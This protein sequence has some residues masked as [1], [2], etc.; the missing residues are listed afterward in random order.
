ML[1]LGTELFFAFWTASKSVGL[2]ERSPPPVRAATSMFLISLA[3]SLPRLAS[4]PAFLCLVVAHLEWPLIGISSLVPG[5]SAG[6]LGQVAAD[7]LDEQRVHPAVPGQ[8]GVEAGGHQVPLADGDDPTVG[9]SADDPAE[10]LDPLAG[11][12]HPRRAD[13]DGVHRRPRRARSKAMSASK[14]STCRPK[15]LRRTV[16]SSPPI[17][18]WSGGASRIRSASRIIP[19]HEP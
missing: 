6:L 7:D 4:M 16:T 11:L 5:S 15:A 2:P 1:S 17:V 18:S 8:F 12:L 10:D 9:R 14:E 19:A 3:K 13:E